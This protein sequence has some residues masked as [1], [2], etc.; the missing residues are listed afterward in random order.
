MLTPQCPKNSLGTR[1]KPKK[2]RKK[3]PAGETAVSRFEYDPCG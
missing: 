2:E 1:E 3:R